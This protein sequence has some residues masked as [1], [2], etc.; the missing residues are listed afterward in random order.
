MAAISVPAWFH[1]PGNKIMVFTFKQLII[2]HQLFNKTARSRSDYWKAWQNFEVAI[3]TSFSI[4]AR[5]FSRYSASF[6]ASGG[7]D[8]SRIRRIPAI[9][10]AACLRSP[11]F[12]YSRPRFQQAIDSPLLSSIFAG[13]D[14]LLLVVLDCPVVSPDLRSHAQ[15]AEWAPSPSGPRSHEL[16]SAPARSTRWPCWSRP[17]Y[18]KA[19]PVAE[20]VSF[21][22]SVPDLAGYFS[23][24]S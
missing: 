21:S 18:S 24:C 23:A 13:D 19:L 16:S 22:P 8:F 20:V 9:R 12:S 1:T 10:S 6:S 11:A 4:L 14:K 17:D 3:F 7:R 2:L 5:R 15:V